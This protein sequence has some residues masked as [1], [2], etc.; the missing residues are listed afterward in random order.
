LLVSISTRSK[1]HWVY[2]EF[3]SGKYT[4]C[5]SDEV[6]FEYEEVLSR[7]L[8]KETAVAVI[9]AISNSSNTLHTDVYYKWNLIEA[10][11]DD[12][13]FVD[14]ALAA[15]AKFIVSEDRHFSV[16]KNISF[17]RVEVLSIEEFRSMLQ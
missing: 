2:N 13:K 1:Y 3:L 17:P 14:C 8:G 12:N 6:L 10:D 5:V 7:H 15:N 16:L 11:K 4:L 9:G